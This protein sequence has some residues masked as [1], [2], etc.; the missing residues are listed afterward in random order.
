LL[1]SGTTEPIPASD[2]R[3]TADRARV[4]RAAQR[5]AA[6]IRSERG[7]TLTELLITMLILV[8]VLGATLALLDTSSKVAVNN[9]E[10]SISLGEAQTGVYRMTRDIRQAASTSYLSATPTTAGNALDVIVKGVRVLYDCTRTSPTNSAYKACY[11]TTS[12]NTSV[13]PPTTGGTAVIDR[14]LNGTTNDSTAVF[15]PL[16]PSGATAPTGYTVQVDTPGKGSRR[17]GFAHLVSF[18][19]AVYLRNATGSGL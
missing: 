1:P 11:R 13:A 15:T 17:S 16:V 2:V 7:F 12:S 9:N 19:D 14:V 4:R 6:R 18:N 5:I 3:A 10:Q 8:V